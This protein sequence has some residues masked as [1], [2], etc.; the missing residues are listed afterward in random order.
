MANRSIFALC[1]LT[2]FGISQAAF[3]E[4]HVGGETQPDTGAMSNMTMGDGAAQTGMMSGDMMS[5]MQNMMKMMPEADD[6]GEA[7]A[8]GSNDKEGET[9]HHGR[10]LHL[11]QGH[12]LGV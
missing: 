6:K 9:P 11:R 2:T 7:K 8:G 10:S 3:A 5:M 12:R 1:V 4:S